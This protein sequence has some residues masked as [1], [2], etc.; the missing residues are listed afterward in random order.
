M[1]KRMYSLEDGKDDIR[2][3]QK[4]IDRFFIVTQSTHKDGYHLDHTTPIMP[5]RMTWEAIYLNTI[6]SQ[7]K[8]KT[9]KMGI[10]NLLIKAYLGE[11]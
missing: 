8:P 7:E 2:Q 9:M 5:I 1:I 11:I 6:L 4:F 3:D 10:E